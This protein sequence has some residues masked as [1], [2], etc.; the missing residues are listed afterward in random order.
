MQ[1]LFYFAAMGSLC[2]TSTWCEPRQKMI[3]HSLV[4]WHWRYDKWFHFISCVRGGAC[5]FCIFCFFVS[6]KPENNFKKVFNVCKFTKCFNCS[7]D[8]LPCHYLT[9]V[10]LQNKQ[11]AR[12]IRGHEECFHELQWTFINP[13]TFC[14]SMWWMYARGKWLSI[15]EGHQIIVVLQAEPVG[16]K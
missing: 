9:R 14:S 3:W 16:L 8:K 15:L 4:I 11:K 5:W 12:L 2:M 7:L 10:I 6:S 13:T 1:D